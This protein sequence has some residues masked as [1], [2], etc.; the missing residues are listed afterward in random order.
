MSQLESFFIICPP[1]LTDELEL[2]L[3]EVWPFLEDESGRPQ[4]TPLIKQKTLGGI[5]LETRPLIGFQLNRVLKLASRI[6]WRRARF[7]AREL[8]QLEGQLKSLPWTEWIP[9]G[10][11]VKFSISASGS[12]VNNEKR[13]EDMLQRLL[14]KRL[15]VMKDH[16]DFHFYLRHHENQMTVSLDTSGE[17]LHKRGRVQ[18]KLQA[19]LR[20][21]LA[22]AALRWMLN[23]VS[24]S[25]LNRI[26]WLDPMAGSGTH[27][28]ELLDHR[29]LGT[30]ED[31]AFNS[32][33]EMP[34]IFRSPEFWK[35]HVLAKGIPFRNLVL[36]DQSADAVNVM[37]KNFESCQ[38]RNIILLQKDL[39]SIDSRDDYGISRNEAL[40][41]VLNPPYG[42]RLELSDPRKEILKMREQIWQKLQPQRLGLWVPASLGN[43]NFPE[44]LLQKREL[45][46]GGIPV[47]FYVWEREV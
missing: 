12:K 32:F 8:F 10:K 36:A 35:N 13:I 20:E 38:E 26:T 23:D 34:K 5:F 19:P 6:L 25:E 40:Y 14:G 15:K 22:S 42:E 33:K 18:F 46:N 9:E 37:K 4:L 39:F 43:L 11:K 2:E 27:G 44:K 3:E 29:G 41:I 17:H 45:R 7:K 47:H 21:T 1:E 28:A 31:Y 30:R 16:E 24:S